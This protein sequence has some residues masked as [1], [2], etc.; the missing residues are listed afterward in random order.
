LSHD[1]TFALQ[2]FYPQVNFGH[3]PRDLGTSTSSLV[4]SKE[5]N[6]TLSINW[7][8]MATIE[9]SVFI[10]VADIQSQFSLTVRTLHYNDLIDED[11]VGFYSVVIPGASPSF[12]ETANNQSDVGFA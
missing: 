7:H 12:P 3:V 8:E 9:S 6:A 2:A 5:L 4:L 11:R 1:R 10:G